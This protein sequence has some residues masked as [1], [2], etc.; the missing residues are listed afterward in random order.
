MMRS[1]TGV[2]TGAEPFALRYRGE[3]LGWSDYRRFTE[4]A[5]SYRDYLARAEA[6]LALL[7]AMNDGRVDWCVESLRRE[8]SGLGMPVHRRTD[9][10][11]F[12][13]PDEPAAWRTL[14]RIG[15]DQSPSV[16]ME[17]PAALL[18]P[19]SD[20]LDIRSPSDRRCAAMA[21]AAWTL[22]AYPGKSARSVVRVWERSKPIPSQDTRARVRAI[23][24]AP[25]NVF[26][27]DAREGECAQLRPLLPMSSDA[28]PSEPVSIS[29]LR[30]VQGVPGDL[31]VARIA[32]GRRVSRVVVGFT[33]GGRPRDELLD[34][35]L[36]E[37][38]LHTRLWNRRAT[39]DDALRERGDLLVCRLH[40]WA[41]RR[42]HQ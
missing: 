16:G 26:A 31:V 40:E 27:I 10:R 41:W 14:L 12:D 2:S 34:R 39:V 5:L 6:L 15:A 11:R 32:R 22:H 33:L 42:A 28:V 17:G 20:V 19:W 24:R 38:L 8:A 29:E 7:D 37:C 1:E 23:V 9:R 36:E 18:G 21:A 4:G 35:W 13:W 30:S 3:Q 25:W